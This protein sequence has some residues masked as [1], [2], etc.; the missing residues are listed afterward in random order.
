MQSINHRVG[1]NDQRNNFN[2]AGK[3]PGWK[4]CFGTSAHMF[5][6][7]YVRE[8]LAMDDKQLAEYVDQAE[9]SVGIVGVAEAVIRKMPWIPQSGSSYYWDVHKAVLNS[10][11]DRHGVDVQA[12]WFDAGSWE[13]FMDDLAKGPLIVGTSRMG[14]L[15]GGHIVLVVGWNDDAKAFILNDPYGNPLSAYRN[16]NGAGVEVPADWFRVQAGKSTK[17]GRVRYMRATPII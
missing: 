11:F 2:F 7:Y 12:Q 13:Q 9:A 14:G 6:S 10:L 1:H 16:H 8:I 3:F 4:Q 5:V 15:P 17:P